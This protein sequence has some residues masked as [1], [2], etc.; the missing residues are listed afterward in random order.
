MLN[1]LILSAM[2]YLEMTL[3]YLNP[4]YDPNY[5]IKIKK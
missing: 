1:I 2:W 5:D 4:K 3:E